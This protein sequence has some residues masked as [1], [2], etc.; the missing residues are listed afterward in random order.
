MNVGAD[1]ESVLVVATHATGVVVA[2]TGA[3]TA[4]VAAEVETA[5]VGRSHR[6]AK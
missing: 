1:L 4:R 2:D 6:S 3:G 5:K